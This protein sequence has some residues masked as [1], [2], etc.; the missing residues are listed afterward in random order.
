MKI[1]TGAAICNEC[2]WRSSSMLSS[3]AKELGVVHVIS[4][5]PDIYTLVTGKKPE[6][7]TSQLLELVLYTDPEYPGR[8]PEL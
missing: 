2:G 1:D 4:W 3:L 7:S 6:V 5:H 8:R